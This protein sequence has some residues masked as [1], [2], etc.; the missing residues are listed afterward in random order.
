MTPPKPAAT[1]TAALALAALGPAPALADDAVH[2]ALELAGGVS[3][4]EQHGRLRYRARLA[5]GV[6]LGL[7]TRHGSV[8]EH[9]VAGYAV[10]EGY[11][12]EHRLELLVPVYDD[13][14]LWWG[15]ELAPGVRHYLGPEDQR[16]DLDRGV[17][18]VF[19]AAVLANVRLDRT[20]TVQAGVR[21]PFS[22]EIT[23]AVVNDVVGGLLVGGATVAV[24]DRFQLF[25]QLETGGL[26]GADGDGAKFLLRGT[27]GAR[28]LFGAGA[29][30]RD[31]T[32]F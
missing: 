21:I 8:R 5:R 14:E 24:S 7:S 12:G 4:F 15:V 28:V 32:T 16:A 2:H 6:Q 9:F 23:P 19:D 18:V 22:L 20:W 3:N 27:A 11:L 29:P 10:D 25:G 13:G 30:A 26:F 1:L 31:W 17:A